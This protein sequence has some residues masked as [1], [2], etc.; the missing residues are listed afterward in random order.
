MDNRLY[1][2]HLKIGKTS[3]THKGKDLVTSLNSISYTNF[4]NSLNTLKYTV[5]KIPAGYQH[6]A[7]LLSNLFYGVPTNDWLLCL[8]NNIKDPFNELNVGDIILVPETRL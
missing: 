7:D 3:V 4:V 5:K 6:R 2:N 8:F 1:I